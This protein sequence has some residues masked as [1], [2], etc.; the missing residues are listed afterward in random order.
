MAS[1]TTDNILL[2]GWW[3]CLSLPTTYWIPYFVN[4]ASSSHHKWINWEFIASMIKDTSWALNKLVV[5]V[6]SCVL[7][8]VGSTLLALLSTDHSQTLTL[9]SGRNVIHVD[10][11]LQLSRAK[12]MYTHSDKHYY[13]QRGLSFSTLCWLGTCGTKLNY[14]PVSLTIISGIH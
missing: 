11:L 5:W 6:I 3:V 13:M 4:L 2:S 1:Y 9:I 12:Y 8:L 7:G 14:V 10:R